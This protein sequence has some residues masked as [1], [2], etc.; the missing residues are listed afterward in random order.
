[1]ALTNRHVGGSSRESSTVQ[2]S[3]AVTDTMESIVY[4][5]TN[6]QHT[7]D[8]ADPDICLQHT[9]TVL[10]RLENHEKDHLFLTSKHGKFTTA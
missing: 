6:L 5:E 2:K 1:M 9:D 10:K 8:Y 3:V 4:E 7:Y